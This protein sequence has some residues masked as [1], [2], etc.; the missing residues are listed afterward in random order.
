MSA[1]TNIGFLWS[2]NVTNSEPLLRTGS[3]STAATFSSF[4]GPV[5][6]WC[7]S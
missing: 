5:W 3:I 1:K 2:R 4:W 6:L 7:R